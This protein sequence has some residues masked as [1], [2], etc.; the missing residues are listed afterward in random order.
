[1]YIIS[2]VVSFFC[3]FVMGIEEIESNR[4]AAEKYGLVKPVLT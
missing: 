3:P 2:F 4:M 1:M